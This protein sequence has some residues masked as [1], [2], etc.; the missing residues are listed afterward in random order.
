MVISSRCLNAVYQCVQFMML[1][2]LLLEP[3]AQC[4]NS[5][6]TGSW[7]FEPWVKSVN[8]KTVHDRIQW[9]LFLYI[10]S[11][12]MHVAYHYTAVTIDRF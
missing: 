1:L 8:T 11:H 6:A 7:H 2:W 4:W 5:L 10:S 9:N 12:P 3:A